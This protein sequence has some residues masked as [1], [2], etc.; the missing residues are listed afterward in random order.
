MRKEISSYKG[1]QV[2][3]WDLIPGGYGWNRSRGIK[4]KSLERSSPSIN[5]LKMYSPYLNGS[6]VGLGQNSRLWGPPTCYGPY[7]YVQGEGPSSGRL[8]ICSMEVGGGGGRSEDMFKGTICLVSYFTRV[9]F[10]HNNTWDC[11]ELIHEK[12]YN[13]SMNI[14]AIGYVLFRQLLFRMSQGVSRVKREQ[15]A[16][17]LR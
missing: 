17:A 7:T 1:G 2:W 12:D 3:G 9:G 15:V 13:Y 5:G 4:K 10:W 8:N 14:Y 11:S 6:Q 16:K